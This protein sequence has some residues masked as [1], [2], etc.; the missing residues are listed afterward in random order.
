MT[1]LSVS[2]LNCESTRLKARVVPSAAHPHSGQSLSRSAR[3]KDK[4]L[5][6]LAESRQERGLDAPNEA[7]LR[8]ARRMGYPPVINTLHLNAPRGG[9]VAQ[10]STLWPISGDSIGWTA[11]P[12]VAT[13]LGIDFRAPSSIA[14]GFCATLPDGS[15][16]R[17][18]YSFAANGGHQ[19][20]C[21]PC[22]PTV[23]RN[24][25]RSSFAVCPS[26]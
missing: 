23:K 25:K 9:N 26:A 13:R 22:A 19:N 8:A 5:L 3:A 4:S 16:P 18:K 20:G 6:E 17:H 15:R 2:A 7:P 1:S 21:A 10:T 11:K 12:P 14:A 24:W